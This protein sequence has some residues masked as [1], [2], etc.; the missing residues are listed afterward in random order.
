MKDELSEQELLQLLQADELSTGAAH[1]A[2]VL[3]AARSFTDGAELPV[4]GARLAEAPAEFRWPAVAGARAYR[5]TLRDAGARI[6]WG[7]PR[8]ATNRAAFD[9]S[10]RQALRPQTY[11]WT[12]TVE[13]PAA[14]AE[15]GPFWFELESL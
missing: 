1:D 2:A 11:Y 12:V 13:G 3:A 15:L 7:S 5:I 4:N 6:F 10:P 14:I 9:K 8:V